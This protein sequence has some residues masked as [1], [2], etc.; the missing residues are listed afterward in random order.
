MSYDEYAIRMKAVFVFHETIVKGL[1]AGTMPQCVINV[2]SEFT[3]KPGQLFTFRTKPGELT[4]VV[5]LTGKGETLHPMADLA[6]ALEELVG[7]SLSVGKYRRVSALV[8]AITTE[9]WEKLLL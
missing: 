5:S 8:K 7:R 9:E 1:I 2:K 4:L 3:H 6:D